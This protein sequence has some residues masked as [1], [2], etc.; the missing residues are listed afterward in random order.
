MLIVDV[1]TDGGGRVCR[2]DPHGEC[3]CER[4][5]AFGDS[6]GIC[7]AC[8]RLNGGACRG[9]QG[10]WGGLGALRRLRAWEERDVWSRA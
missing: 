10:K 7:E 8:S 4:V 9:L 1:C 6:C 5:W 2:G 3:I